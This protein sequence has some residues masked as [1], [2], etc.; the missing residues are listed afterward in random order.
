MIRK[1]FRG[2]LWNGFSQNPRTGRIFSNTIFFSIFYSK[3]KE[4]LNWHPLCLFSCLE[5]LNCLECN[6]GL[7][8]QL[9]NSLWLYG[10]HWAGGLRALWALGQL[11][12]SLEQPLPLPICLLASVSSPCSLVPADPFLCLKISSDNLP[13]IPLNFLGLPGELLLNSLHKVVQNTLNIASDRDRCSWTK[14]K[15][16]NKK[17]LTERLMSPRS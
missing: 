7:V 14:G 4:F 10:N 2:H 16:K 17:N 13:D 5:S 9:C 12:V 8:L 11:C 6:G 15:T 1:F 3:W